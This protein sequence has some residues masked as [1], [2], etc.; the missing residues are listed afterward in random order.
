MFV[1]RYALHHSGG[2][3]IT[4]GALAADALVY[5]GYSAGPCVLAPSLRGLDA[6]DDPAAVTATYGAEP[7]WEGLGNHRVPS[8][9]WVGELGNDGGGLGAERPG[10]RPAL[11]DVE[12]VGHG[13]PLPGHQRPGL[14][15]L[16]R[17]R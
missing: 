1:L 16:P 15:E 6:V 3:A 11:P 10:Q 9:V 14:A 2:D 7:I 5:A 17:L 8:A 13:L 12:E 4:A